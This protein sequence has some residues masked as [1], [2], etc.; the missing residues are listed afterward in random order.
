MISY[1]TARL[2]ICEQIGKLGTAV[3]EERVALPEA[4]GRVLARDVA[5][6]R[7]YPPFDRSARDGY[8]VRAA[9]AVAGATLL[10]VGEIKAGDVP[11]AFSGHGTCLQIMTGAPVP[12]GA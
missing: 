7:D 8:A 5:A 2:I 6:D 3:T 12:R 4:H 10:C 1:Q 11:P 9:E